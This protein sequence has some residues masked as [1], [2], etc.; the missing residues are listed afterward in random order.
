[1]SIR[2]LL[3]DV[4]TVWGT[5]EATADGVGGFKR[6]VKKI[7]EN[8]PVRIS[9][10][11]ASERYTNEVLDRKVTH[12]LYT[13]NEI[14]VGQYVEHDNKDYAILRVGEYKDI[15]GIESYY[16]ADCEVKNE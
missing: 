9:T 10:R 15:R 5:N 2:R 7:H 12:K 1:M 8:I 6:T 14:N 4:V 11:N 13:V 16:V 3:T